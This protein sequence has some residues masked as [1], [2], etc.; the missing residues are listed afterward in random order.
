MGR[1]SWRLA[2]VTDVRPET[3]RVVT[4]ALEAPDWDGHL[5]GQHVDV[6]AGAV[7]RPAG[8]AERDRLDSGRLGA[9]FRD[10]RGFPA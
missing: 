4:L 5:P 7:A 8:D 6:L 9:D 10:R 2:T 1:L 3:E